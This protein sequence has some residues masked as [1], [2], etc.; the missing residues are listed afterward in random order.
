MSQNIYEQTALVSLTST[1]CF[2]RFAGG[3]ADYHARGLS[4]LIDCWIESHLHGKHETRLRIVGYSFQTQHGKN[5]VFLSTS[6]HLK[7]WCMELK[8][9]NTFDVWF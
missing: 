3:D 1:Y 5:M 2:L 7:I 8:I 6:Y 4:R 9:P